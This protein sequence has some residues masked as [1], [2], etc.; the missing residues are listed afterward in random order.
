MNMFDEMELALI[1]ASRMQRAAAEELGL[2]FADAY[3]EE[4]ESLRLFLATAE[5][6]RPSDINA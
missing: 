6:A 5:A 2:S 3:P 4:A 1:E